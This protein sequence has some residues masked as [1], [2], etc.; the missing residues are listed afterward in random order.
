MRRRPITRIYGIK[1]QAN[2]Y[3]MEPRYSDNEL[4]FFKIVLNK[5]LEMATET[6]KELKIVLNRSEENGTDD[7]YSSPKSF[8]DGSDTLAQE[9]Q[10][11]QAEKQEK[12]IERLKNALIRIENKTYGICRVTGEL[13][14]RERLL[15]VP[16]ATTTVGAKTKEN[17]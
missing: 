7:T 2:F 11:I 1:T 13:I 16:H 8:E 17:L 12:F 3:T 4:A 10:N 14:P 9:T 15:A 5:K 6:L